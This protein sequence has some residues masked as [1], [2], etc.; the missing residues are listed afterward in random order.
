MPKEL[1]LL[2]DLRTAFRS[3]ARSPGFVLVAVVAL[4]LG[5]GLSTTMF[6]VLDAIVHPASPYK[7]P[8]RLYTLAFWYG[9]RA[10]LTRDDLYRVVREQAR[11]FDA[12][13]PRG[14]QTATLAS[15]GEESDIYV[16]TVPPRWFAVTGVAP[17]LG[18]AFAA[19]DGDGVAV[20]SRWLWK[21]LYGQRTSLAG[22]RVTFSD[23]T[24]AVVGVMSREGSPVNGPAAWLPMPVEGELARMGWSSLVHLKPGVTA[25]QARAELKTLSDALTASRHSPDY[26]YALLLEPVRQ[27]QEELSDIHKAMVGAALVVLLIACVNLAHLMLARGMAKRRELAVRMALGAPRAAVIRLMLM[28]CGLITLGGGVLG[29]LATVW[30]RGVLETAMPPEVAWVG[31]LQ[32]Q[33]SWRVF[34]LSAV[35]AVLSAALFGLVPALRV[36]YA[37]ELTEP[38]KDAGT[39]TARTRQR[40]SPLVISEV[41]LALVLLMGGGLLLRTVAQLRRETAGLNIQT[42][43]SAWVG[44]KAASEQT[45]SAVEWDQAVA[46]VRA[47][48]GVALVAS[49][50]TRPVAGLAMSPEQSED[51]SRLLLMHEVP[52][53]SS[54]YMR[55]MGLPI[56]RGRNFEPGDAAGNGAAIL[57]AVAAE[58]LYPRQNPV[59]RMIKLGAARKDAP[60]VTIVGVARS[61]IESRFGVEIL[62]QPQVWVSRRDT[63]TRRTFGLLVIRTVRRDPRV[64]A[65]V[66]RQLRTVPSV[67]FAQVYSYAR[68]RDAEI[69]SRAFLAD[70]FVGMGAIALALAALGLYGVLSYAVTQRMREYGVRLALGAQP[71]ALFRSVFHDAA[72]M[73]LAGIGVGAFFALAAARLLDSVLVAVLPSDVVSLAAAEA[74]LFIAGFLAAL[75]PARR[76]ARSDPLEILRAA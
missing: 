37:V 11:S 66:R 58:R 41:A 55:A 48:P 67:G 38:L 18:R 20:L 9:P 36:A 21:R 69:A 10:T 64:V 29:V 61:E 12:I 52:V 47:V 45:R 73:V 28:E 62:R 35:A 50:Q 33:L 24:Y 5:L 75:G 40:Y 56:L 51:T 65:Q 68:A 8:D 3:L 76:A 74:V 6:A 60:W 44:G 46:A 53:V 19:S 70:V 22:A 1:P 34:A 54:D 59:G 26:P 30:G 14:G 49:E 16:Q 25:D 27:R 23:R 43:L 32:P 39:T 15:G 71:R 7:D 2:A 17:E 72:V 63:V 42:L 4:G 57:N 13:V 31:I